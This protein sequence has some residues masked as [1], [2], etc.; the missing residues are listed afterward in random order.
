MG[1]I[2]PKSPYQGVQDG[3]SC[4]GTGR[5]SGVAWRRGGRSRNK[6]PG[7]LQK[8]EKQENGFSAK[9][10]LLPA[11]L[12]L[13]DFGLLTQ[14]EKI[15]RIWCSSKPPSL[16]QSVTAAK[17][18]MTAPCLH[19]ATRSGMKPRHSLLKEQ[20]G[21]GPLFPPHGGRAAQ[22]PPPRGVWCLLGWPRQ[23]TAGISSATLF[24]LAELEFL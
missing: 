16:Q 19:F 4:K 23:K 5:F 22:C 3:G 8:V 17:E 1:I 18:T 6:D 12:V 10:C 24:F 13:A 9:E 20:E 11:P 7:R 14:K 15:R 2:N 21:P